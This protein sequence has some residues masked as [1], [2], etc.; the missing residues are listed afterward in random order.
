LALRHK[1]NFIADS[2]HPRVARRG[3]F[4]LVE[5]ALSESI[6][7][8]QQRFE[9]KKESLNHLVR[10]VIGPVESIIPSIAPVTVLHFSADL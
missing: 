9:F 4:L 5:F 8:R 10:F 6:P 2:L 7:D 1:F 3:G